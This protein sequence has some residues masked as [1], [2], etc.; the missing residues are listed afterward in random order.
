MQ[1]SRNAFCNFAADDF[2]E[3]VFGL[4]LKFWT[5]IGH[6]YVLN[7]LL[8]NLGPESAFGSVFRQF[9]AET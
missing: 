4:A 6:D 1:K 8:G 3:V 9:N 7:W 2:G 5:T